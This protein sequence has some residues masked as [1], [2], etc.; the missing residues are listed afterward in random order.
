[1]GHFRASEVAH[2]RRLK[3]ENR[4]AAYVFQRARYN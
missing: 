4:I 2:L 1:M 3:Q